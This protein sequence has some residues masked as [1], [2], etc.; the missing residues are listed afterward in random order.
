VGL[1]Y[2]AEA[3]TSQQGAALGTEG[4]ESQL[5]P[6]QFRPPAPLSQ[7]L[8]QVEAPQQPPP[9]PPPQPQ[10]QQP[11]PPVPE[12]LPTARSGSG[13]SKGKKSKSVSTA[14]TLR[15]IA[16]ER[17]RPAGVIDVDQLS[18]VDEGRPASPEASSIPD[19]V[20]A[21]PPP[22]PVSPVRKPAKTSPRKL[23]VMP[24][25]AERERRQMGDMVAF[26]G[27]KD[28]PTKRQESPAKRQESAAEKPKR[29]KTKVDNG[30]GKE[31]E[32]DEPELQFGDEEEEQEEEEA[33]SSFSQQAVNLNLA[34]S[35][36]TTRRRRKELE[37][38]V[39]SEVL[40]KRSEAAVFAELA[41]QAKGGG[42]SSPP[43]PPPKTPTKAAAS[44]KQSAPKSKSRTPKTRGRT[45]VAAPEVVDVDEPEQ[46][47]Q[48][49]A[50]WTL[51]KKQ[52]EE[53][54]QQQQPEV[55]VLESQSSQHVIATAAMPPSAFIKPQM[56]E[57]PKAA[58]A[59]VG[60][61][62][63]VDE[64]E[65][66]AAFRIP[67]DQTAKE[68]VYD[69]SQASQLQTAPLD[70]DDEPF[71][72]AP[73]DLSAS[74]AATPED[75]L[76]Q[77]EKVAKKLRFSSST[78]GVKKPK[79]K[80]TLP[81]S[82]KKKG[83]KWLKGNIRGVAVQFCEPR[84]PKKIFAG[85]KFIVTGCK[86]VN[87]LDPPDKHIAFMVN[88]GSE[89]EPRKQVLSEWIHDVIVHHGGSELMYEK[90]T[91]QQRLASQVEPLAGTPFPSNTI[92][93]SERPHRTIKWMLALAAGVPC[94]KWE[95]LHECVKNDKLMDYAPFIL[96]AG[97]S[98]VSGK[99]IRFQAR[100]ATLVFDRQ[101][102]E[103][104]GSAMFREQ[105]SMVLREQGAECVQRLG[106]GN[107]SSL[108]MV[109]SEET[110]E[111]PTQQ[112]VRS[113]RKLKIAIVSIEFVIQSILHHKLFKVSDFP[114][115]FRAKRKE[116]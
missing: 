14:T 10:Q 87:E 113:A 53:R 4:E 5:P 21:M 64:E 103:V 33:G 57:K 24:D 16:I 95:W 7:P 44:P 97:L 49:K 91:Q 115:R 26:L 88:V 41:K 48:K 66:A 98:I 101:K 35:S 65:E 73:G 107:E 79:K 13:A 85:L 42:E 67:W 36:R 61:M 78:A 56:Q 90:V 51:K 20:D 80:A 22:S 89:E 46:T 82:G 29:K 86:V 109:L 30:K 104:C 112:T 19:V 47:P 40:Q 23:L 25:A 6:F 11:P 102:I 81:S 92:C 58:E 17:K 63:E 99:L 12:Q 59:E 9:Q 2:E 84:N 83:V 114:D 93:I 43:P 108:D 71:R 100:P 32:E 94:V 106:M 74:F 111:Y 34:G 75:A 70:E 15:E 116:D 96:R 1:Q 39:G 76:D 110:D 38:L 37:K 31:E 45:P 105:W 52:P 28:S 68:R 54:Q 8:A 55:V 18:D 72:P 62:E 60:G 69:L 27:R 3:K 50:K 77:P